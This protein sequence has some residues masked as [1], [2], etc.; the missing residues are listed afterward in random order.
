MKERNGWALGQD[1]ME[2]KNEQAAEIKRDSTEEKAQLQQL[3]NELEKGRAIDDH[4]RQ[5]RP[6]YETMQSLYAAHANANEIAQDKERNSP[7]RQH[8]RYPNNDL[9]RNMDDDFER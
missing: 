5:P 6:D 8:L 2:T 9:T 4:Q 7:E 1:V 3:K